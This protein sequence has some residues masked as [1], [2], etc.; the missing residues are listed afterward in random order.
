MGLP[1]DGWNLSHLAKCSFLETILQQF[2]IQTG[3]R[4]LQD[5]SSFFQRIRK[6]N[7]VMSQGLHKQLRGPIVYRCDINMSSLYF[8]I[9]II[10]FFFYSGGLNYLCFTSYLK[11]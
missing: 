11:S 4:S 10:S 1:Y 2:R 7:F 9:M 8:V 5:K 6:V 3:K